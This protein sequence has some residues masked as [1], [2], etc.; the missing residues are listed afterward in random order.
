MRRPLLLSLAL[1]LPASLAF[2]DP[3]SAAP[4]RAC[5]T[6]IDV[7]FDTTIARPGADSLVAFL[8]G[9]P[10]PA[11]PADLRSVREGSV[12][13]R[14]VVDTAGRVDKFQQRAAKTAEMQAAKAS[15]STK[16]KK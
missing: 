16:K 4:P 12:V 10:G 3:A 2:R 7:R 6:A 8:L 11:F 13:A 5:R 15:V 1:L 14:F 9:G